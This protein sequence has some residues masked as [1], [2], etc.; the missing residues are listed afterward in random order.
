MSSLGKVL[1][2]GQSRSV[3]GALH[4]VGSLVVRVGSIDFEPSRLDRVAGARG[5]SVSTH[6]VTRLVYHENDE[7]LEVWKGEAVHV[8]EG[9]TLEEVDF[10]VRRALSLDPR[11]G[12]SRPA[13]QPD[14][15]I[16]MTLPAR[17][18]HAGTIRCGALTL[19]TRRLSFAHGGLDRVEAGPLGFDVAL[20]RIRDVRWDGGILLVTP[21]SAFEIHAPQGSR[22]FAALCGEGSTSLA[23]DGFRT[24]EAYLRATTSSVRGLL[25]ITRTRLRFESEEE[26]GRVEI[27]LL[28]VTS[29]SLEWG[30]LV[31]RRGTRAWRFVVP[32]AVPLHA[33]LVRLLTELRGKN[34]PTADEMGCFNERAIEWVL[35]TRTRPIPGFTPGRVSIAGP[36]VVV[37]AH[38][39]ARRGAILL[40][41]AGAAFVPFHDP[42]AI[43]P[44]LVA[45]LETLWARPAGEDATHG[46][47]ERSGSDSFDLH[48]VGGAAFLER[49]RMR[50]KRLV[51][52]QRQATSDSGNRRASYRVSPREH[53]PTSVVPLRD[54]RPSN[55]PPISGRLADLS[56]DGCRI[57]S[58]RPIERCSTV[59]VEIRGSNPPQSLFAD[60]VHASPP[61]SSTP[62][63]R[64]GL[65]FV[66]RTPDQDR[67]L[68]E[69]WMEYQRKELE[70]YRDK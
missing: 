41:E 24:H 43:E 20:E 53:V 55:E 33:E 46:T 19:T 54:G 8:L 52:A 51:D 21:D 18:T 37:T 29:A 58:D 70:L 64:Y 10:A 7:L 17:V 12:P 42:D 31:V 14:E 16:V 25:S 40:G 2:E 67:R 28:E 62:S 56:A 1:F 34:E 47:F 61:T 30:D 32:H 36:A 15:Q 35:A 66:R 3:R 6:E 65:R 45:S 63:W 44:I 57:I 50:L 9:K 59:E 48:P 27:P 13:L 11:L 60:I 26:G 23:R 69:L 39:G 22:L 38:E 5:W 68:R 4:T 49:F